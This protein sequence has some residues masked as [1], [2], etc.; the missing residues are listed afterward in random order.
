LFFVVAEAK[1]I[2]LQRGIEI[3]KQ[4]L[5]FRASAPKDSGV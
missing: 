2:L 3:K 1:E 4:A 5:I